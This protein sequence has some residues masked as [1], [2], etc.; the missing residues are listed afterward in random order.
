MIREPRAANR[1]L[2]ILEKMSGGGG[3]P[4]SQ[5]YGKIRR[6]GM[7]EKQRELNYLLSWVEGCQY[8][9]YRWGW[10]GDPHE[11]PLEREAITAGKNI[12]PGFKDISGKHIPFRF[13]RPTAPYQLARAV[14]DRFTGQL[15]SRSV[16]PR[17][18]MLGD[19]KT[20]DYLQ[21]LCEVARMWPAWMR[22]RRHGGAMGTT[23]VGFKFI[24]GKPLIEVHDV[25]W[26][27][28]IFRSL[29]TLELQSID[30]RWQRPKEV[31]VAKDRWETKYVWE[32]RIV[33]DEADTVFHPVWVTD[34]EPDWEAHVDVRVE[35]GFGFCPA[36]WVQNLP[37]SDGGVYGEC[38]IHGL[39]D[40]IR[41]IDELLSASAAGTLG[42]CDPTLVL[43]STGK[44]A[45]ELRKGS[46]NAIKFEGVDGS[47]QYL[48]MSGTGAQAA[49]EQ[50]KE[51]R[52]RFLECAQCVLDMAQSEGPDRTATEI[53][54]KHGPMA[55]KVGV[56][57]EQY[58]EMGLKPL[59]D[60]MLDA[61]RILEG[62]GLKV[63]VPPKVVKDT[64]TGKVERKDRVLGPGDGQLHVEWSLSEE[65]QPADALQAVQAASMAQ[66]SGLLDRVHAVK[67]TGK[68]FN[69][70]DP[71]QML[72]E[73]QEAEEEQQAEQE[74]KE[75]EMMQQGIGPDGSPLPPQPGEPPAPPQGPQPAQPPQPKAPQGG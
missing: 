60:K 12:P 34:E 28:P 11:T 6:L 55:Q 18:T 62:R 49:R 17:V 31:E 65:P 2:S 42:N 69:V 71:L 63:L 75:Q 37:A 67:Y 51:T 3:T 74:Q 27:T 43:Q 30:I 33:D 41:Q 59:L 73:M 47:A 24:E 64:Q 22:A 70:E 72:R 38:D 44:I 68:Y 20:E 13:R 29:D 15:F 16:H 48:E 9:A 45:S 4:N 8:D 58:G 10:D 5:V 61:I 14:V 39:H 1:V 46:G 54:K 40:M 36:V 35:H 23:C 56:L 53:D 26:I 32:R 19:D 21:G 7:T 52:E 66:Q 25:R 57:Q 50:A